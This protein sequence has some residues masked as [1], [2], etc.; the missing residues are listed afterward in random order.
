MSI[1][2]I[3]EPASGQNG[4]GMGWGWDG[5]GMGKLWRWNGLWDVTVFVTSQSLG[6]RGRDVTNIW[7][8][9]E[10]GGLSFARIS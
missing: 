5:E 1:S 3:S 4:M 10:M 2:K 8:E 9:G 7:G 6:T